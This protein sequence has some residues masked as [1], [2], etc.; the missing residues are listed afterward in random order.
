MGV[1]IRLA[2]RRL[3]LQFAELGQ[4]GID[5]ALLAFRHQDANDLPEIV[6]RGEVVAPVVGKVLQAHEIPGLKLLQPH[7]HI[8][9]GETEF[10]GDLLGVQRPVGEE[11]EGVD[12]ANGT[13]DAPARPH[14]AEVQD[15][16]LLERREV[17]C[18]VPITHFRNF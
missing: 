12:L 15:E 8:G 7:R 11:E 1:A 18:A 14:L 16:L 2:G 6:G 10:L 5:L 17:H 13:I 4:R 9:S 3:H